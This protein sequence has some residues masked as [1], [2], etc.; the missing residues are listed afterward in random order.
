[1]TASKAKPAPKPGVMDIT[2][3]VSGRETAP[4]G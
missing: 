1:M 4:R 2:A 3:Y